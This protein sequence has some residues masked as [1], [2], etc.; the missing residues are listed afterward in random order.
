MDKESKSVEG[1]LDEWLDV[2]SKTIP[3]KT[4]KYNTQIAL[5]AS[6]NNGKTSAL[7]LTILKLAE[8]E[9][10]Y[11]AVYK[12]FDDSI[13]KTKKTLR[14]VRIAF[15]KNGRMVYISTIGDTREICEANMYFFL[16]EE[17]HLVDIMRN[18]YVV[19]GKRIKAKEMYDKNLWKI[20]KDHQLSKF[21][22][23]PCHTEGGTV[24][25][26]IYCSD[27]LIEDEKVDRVVW[28]YKKSCPK[29][30]NK[31]FSQEDVKVAED[32]YALFVRTAG[33]QHVV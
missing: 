32:I 7:W 15:P 26:T 21:C 10:F 2:D 12:L 4:L 20:W 25:A 1:I 31:L 13:D 29:N 8:G 33:G 18:H 5:Y 24:D 22:I 16:D 27:M 23:S 28:I 9:P 6:G 19:G 17:K 14:D 3:Q 11:P 30:Q